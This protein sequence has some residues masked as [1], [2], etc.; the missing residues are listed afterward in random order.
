MASEKKNSQGELFA[1]L[2]LL[3]NDQQLKL[4]YFSLESRQVRRDFISSLGFNPDLIRESLSTIPIT[5]GSS[6]TNLLDFLTS[7]GVSENTPLPVGIILSALRSAGSD[8]SLA[9]I[10][11][12]FSE[13]QSKLTSSAGGSAPQRRNIDSVSRRDAER[14]IEREIIDS[15][16]DQGLSDFKDTS[17]PKEMSRDSGDSFASLSRSTDDT[18]SSSAKPDLK[19]ADTESANDAYNLSRFDQ[20]ADQL[21]TF[22][23]ERSDL[24]SSLLDRP[25]NETI[26][27]E[28]RGSSSPVK[29][30]DRSD[31]QTQRLDTSSTRESR[32]KLEASTTDRLEASSKSAEIR[33]D[34]QELSQL[35]RRVDELQKEDPQLFTKYKNAIDSFDS[36]KFT[37]DLTKDFT[38]AKVSRQETID[39]LHS[40]VSDN[41]TRFR[42]DARIRQDVLNRF[43]DSNAKS[44]E[45]KESDLAALSES[46]KTANTTSDTNNSKSSDQNK[47]SDST[48]W[49]QDAYD[50][51]DGIIGLVYEYGIGAS[52]RASWQAALKAA[53]EGK[54][55]TN[56]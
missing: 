51:I 32:D 40:F 36:K 37:N 3:S 5:V 34:S 10:E 9:S 43:T 16:R 53:R 19:S 27:T 30:D 48:D 14:L 1:F 25:A 42:G 41:L 52:A 56:S 54:T 4:K 46:A 24:I 13:F 44:P 29:P 45:E 17:L 8:T 47:D 22:S 6:T 12:S 26:R 2:S 38:D 49:A 35:R 55:T 20:H 33:K 50:A 21:K 39:L 23:S 11:E 31:P 18:F 28:A 7:K 15:S